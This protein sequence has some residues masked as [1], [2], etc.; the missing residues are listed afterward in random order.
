MQYCISCVVITKIHINKLNKFKGCIIFIFAEN[1]VKL[2]KIVN[3][4]EYL[5]L[6]SNTL[7]I[8]LIELLNKILMK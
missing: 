3:S 8:I 2:K 4:T 7:K 1:R 6:N 5:L